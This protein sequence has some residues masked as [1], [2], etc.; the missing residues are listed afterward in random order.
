[1]GGCEY[2]SLI[3]GTG[4]S[5]AVQQ[6]RP[7]DFFI[8]MFYISVADPDPGSGAFLPQGSGIRDDFFSGYRI[9]NPG[10]LPRP[11]FHFDLFI[12]FYSIIYLAVAYIN[13]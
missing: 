12:L 11:K 2:W 10:S 3:T 6:E 4:I 5:S 1:M 8:H 9:S 13:K 7:R